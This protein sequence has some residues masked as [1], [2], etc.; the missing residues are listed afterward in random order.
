MATVLVIG[1]SP[2]IHHLSNLTLWAYYSEC[3]QPRFP[4]NF[5]WGP[6]Q[7]ATIA[8]AA[9]SSWLALPITALSQMYFYTKG[10]AG[11][12]ILAKGD[13]VRSR[14]YLLQKLT[15]DLVRRSNVFTLAYL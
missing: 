11:V 6:H 5:K 13:Q 9:F 7:S 8:E 15:Y 4:R 1:R 10:I 2:K 14:I 3:T 12:Y